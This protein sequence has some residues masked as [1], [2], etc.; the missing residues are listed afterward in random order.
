MKTVLL[1]TSD[2]THRVL[3]DIGL[4][5]HFSVEF[6]SKAQ[7]GHGKVDA[8]VYDIPMRHTTIDL[9]WLTDLDIPVVILTPENLFPLPESPTRRVLTYPVSA[10]EIVHALEELGI[11]AVDSA[12]DTEAETETK[13][14]TET[15]T[16]KQ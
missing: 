14:E 7:G 15:E 11:K 12:E 1:I 2:E 8:V 16:E 4:K 9:R 13:T 3:R 10:G 6:L 5:K